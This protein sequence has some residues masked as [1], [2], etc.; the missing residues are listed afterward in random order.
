MKYLKHVG[1]IGVLLVVAG[2]ASAQVA[3]G[4]AVG[5]G[6][7]LGPP[8]DC[9]NGYYGYYPYAC[10][11]YGYYGPGYFVNG[12]FIGAGPWFHGYYG[13]GYYDRGYYGHGFYA[14]PGYG[15]RG[16]WGNGYRE[17]RGGRWYG[18]VRGGYY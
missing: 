7:V 6:Y 2:T 15:Y 13:S 3:V 10:A 12:I 16:G 4:V 5:P 11:P 14:R 1:F 8:P 18:H 17:I 9:T